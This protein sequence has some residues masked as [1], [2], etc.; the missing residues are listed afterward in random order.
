[1]SHAMG[2]I[3]QYDKKDKDELISYFAGFLTHYAIDKNSHPLFYEKADGSIGIH[4]ALEYMLDSYTLKEQWDR[5]QYFDAFSDLEY[6]EL[7][8]GISS[9]YASVASKV[10]ERN[11]RHSSTTYA[12]LHF[13]RSKRRMYTNPALTIRLWLWITS[14]FKAKKVLTM[15][16]FDALQQFDESFFSSD[17]YVNMQKMIT[18]GVDEASNLIQFMFRYINKR[19]NSAT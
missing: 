9:W 18:K 12:Q 3:A 10:Y 5:H 11:L 1:M 16:Q 14:G 15:Q 13:A 7:G 19:R 6:D 2:F 4:H 17:E 8:S